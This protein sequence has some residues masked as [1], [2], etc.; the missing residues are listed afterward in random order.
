MAR[1][2]GEASWLGRRRKSGFF[3]IVEEGGEAV[4]DPF[5]AI[6]QAGYDGLGILFVCGMGVNCGEGGA[7]GGRGIESR[8]EAL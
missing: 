1:A 6:L 8:A 4:K 7:E 3:L 5:G 2:A